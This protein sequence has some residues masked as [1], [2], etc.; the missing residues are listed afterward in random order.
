MNYYVNIVHKKIIMKTFEMKTVFNEVWYFVEFLLVGFISFLVV[1]CWNKPKKIII[2][3]NQCITVKN[4][5]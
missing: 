3:I 4:H 5:S 2:Q 1:F